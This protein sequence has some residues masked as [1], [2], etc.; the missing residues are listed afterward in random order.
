[1]SRRR[2][3]IAIAAAALVALLAAG[4]V[5]TFFSA[6]AESAFKSDTEKASYAIGLN[7]ARQLKTIAANI[8]ETALAEGFNDGRSAARK[9]RLTDQEIAATLASLRRMHQQKVKAEHSRAATP[10]MN[11]RGLSVFFKLD[12]RI[13]AAY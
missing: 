7:L 12:P 6:K 8:D 11:G 1:M 4:S 5:G 13:T 3:V 9:P 10:A 2:W